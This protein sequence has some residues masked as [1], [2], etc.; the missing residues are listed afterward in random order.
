MELPSVR[1]P[2]TTLDVSA[3]PVPYPDGTGP[4]TLADER[5]L[6]IR[7]GGRAY[8]ATVHRKTTMEKRVHG[9]TANRVAGSAEAF[10][11]LIADRYLIRLDSITADEQAIL[12][13]AVAGG[14]HETTESPSKAWNR[15]LDRLDDTTFPEAHYTWYVEYNGTW[16]T[17]ALSSDESCRI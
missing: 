7:W 16:Y 8:E 15:L 11:A 10:R 6:W 14:Y 3:S 12:D 9:Y 2:E 17:L 5:K 13:A 1:H 4:S